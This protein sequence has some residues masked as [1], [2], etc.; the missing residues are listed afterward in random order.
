MYQLKMKN[1]YYELEDEKYELYKEEKFVYLIYDEWDYS[2]KK[3]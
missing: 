2:T 1:L 3:I